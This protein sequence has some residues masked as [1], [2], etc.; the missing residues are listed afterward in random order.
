MSRAGLL[1]TLMQVS[2]VPGNTRQLLVLPKPAVRFV[3]LCSR[4]EEV[5]AR[6]D[7]EQ[8]CAAQ[9]HTHISPLRTVFQSP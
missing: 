9:I 6:D 4:T 8:L 1:D 3:H 2:S 5:E 7:L